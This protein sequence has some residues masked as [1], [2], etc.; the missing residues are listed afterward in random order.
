MYIMYY[1]S[2]I[3]PPF[4]IICIIVAYII[5][6][7]FFNLSSGCIFSSSFFALSTKDINDDFLFKSI[8]DTISPIE[9]L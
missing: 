7:S 4:D 2:T 9:E 3:S 8:I 6:F 5:K 1:S